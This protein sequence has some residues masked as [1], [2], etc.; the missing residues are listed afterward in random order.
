MAHDHDNYEDGVSHS[1]PAP[2]FRLAHT[3]SGGTS[4]AATFHVHFG[5]DALPAPLEVRRIEPR[6][7]FLALAEGFDD[8]LEMPTYP[9][10]VGMFYALAGVTI[11]S[12]SSLGNVLHL[13]FPFAAGF[14]L[15]GPFV[16]VGLYE[17]SRRR[18]LGL[19]AT[20][21]DAFAVLRSP[22]L[23]SIL[24][25]GLLLLAIFVAWIGAAQL[26][27]FLLYGPDRPTRRYTF[28]A[29]F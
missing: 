6:D 3:T 23:P 16:A 7:C 20:W 29:T 27:Y 18:E 13:A 21:R 28:F 14:A 17:M 1:S 11:V 5:H 15:V 25:L 19:A 12:L 4:M 24:A 26:L 10:F 2:E 9:V 8:F 22:A